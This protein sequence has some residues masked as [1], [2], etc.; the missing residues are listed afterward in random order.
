MKRIA[1]FLF[2]AGITLSLYAQTR[3][4][5]YRFAAGEWG[6]FGERLLQ[7]DSGA[8]LAKVNF[9]VPQ[10]G[11]MLYNF[12]VLYEDGAEDGHGGFGIHVFS[13]TA[14]NGASWGCGRSYLLWLNYDEHPLSKDI[15]AG[16]SAQIYRSYTNSRME[17]VESISLKDY[18]GYLSAENL[19]DAVPFRIEVYG[20]TGEIRVYDPTDAGQY[21][22]YKVNQRDIPLKGDWVALRTNGLKASFALE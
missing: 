6:F 11:A 2:M 12:N 14:Y 10:S 13:D 5:E 22:Y 1:L 21:Y 4:P 16:L 20:N 17:L 8:R 19:S 15:P 3:I 18:E 7:S 9:R